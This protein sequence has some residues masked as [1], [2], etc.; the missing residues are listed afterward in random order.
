MDP[1]GAPGVSQQLKSVTDTVFG[2]GTDFLAILVVAALVGAFALYFGR[3]RLTPLIAALYA[4]IPLYSAFPFT[5]SL[6]DN[7]Y[8]KIGLYFVFAL[9]GFVTLSGLSYFMASDSIGFL[10]VT[11]LSI[12]TAGLLIAI[13][14]HVLPVEK[15]YSFTP[16]VRTLFA[17]NQAFFWWLAAPLIGLF[18]F[19]R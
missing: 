8:M 5:L 6:L 14:V 15:V 19:G 17:S 12:L 3:D 1:L 13:G 9:I 11:V 4:A 7:P 2:F 18:F 10:R 16:S